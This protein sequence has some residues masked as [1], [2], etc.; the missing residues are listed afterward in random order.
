MQIEALTVGI[1]DSFWTKGKKI[2]KNGHFCPKFQ[3]RG[4]KNDAIV[5]HV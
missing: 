2:V 4:L 5:I 1:F 3:P